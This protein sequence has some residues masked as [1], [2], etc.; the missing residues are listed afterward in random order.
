MDIEKMLENFDAI[1]ASGEQFPVDFDRAWDWI[2]YTR[3]DVAKDA[4]LRNFAI[5]T[6]FTS[7]PEETGKPLGG[8]PAE[9]IFMTVD[10]FKSFC[11]MAGT[12]KGKQVRIYFLQCEAKLK[13]LRD[14]IVPMPVRLPSKKEL[15]KWVIELSEKIEVM[16]P[17]VEAH[18]ILT[19]SEG[20]ASVAD[21]AKVLGTGQKRL[22]ALLRK[23]DILQSRKTHWNLPKQQYIEAG[24]FIVK[25]FVIKKNGEDVLHKQTFILP[26][27]ES[28]IA[29]KFSKLWIQKGIQPMLL[30]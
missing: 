18:E 17:I 2:G 20:A 23:A 10:C 19:N 14:R 30:R 11:M 21:V 12:E 26:K 25:D 9:K 8:R 3:K 15:A 28:F 4:L 24:Y 22:Y 6:D 5:S 16:E 27:G 29:K 1:L 13:E 7:S